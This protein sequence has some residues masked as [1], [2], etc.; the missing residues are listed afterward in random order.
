M[1]TRTASRSCRW[2]TPAGC[3]AHIIGESDRLDDPLSGG[4]MDHTIA[5]LHAHEVATV[6][7]ETPNPMS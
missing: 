1:K 4:A 2:S 6:D 7:P 3:T 5:D